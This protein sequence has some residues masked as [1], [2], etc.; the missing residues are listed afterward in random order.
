M[1]FRQLIFVGVVTFAVVELVLFP[2]SSRKLAEIAIISF[3]GMLQSFLKTGSDYADSME[4][5]AKTLRMGTLHLLEEAID[6]MV[7]HFA[8]LEAQK[9]QLKKTAATITTELPSAFLE[10]HF[11]FA[12]RL[13]TPSLSGLS[14]HLQA[15]VTQ[16]DFLTA[17]LK[18]IQELHDAQES[19][20]FQEID[21][22]QAYA[23]A[24][25]L[26][27]AQM[28]T[29]CQAL[30]Q[31][32]P[33]GRLRPQTKHSAFNASTAAATFRDFGDVRYQVISNW[34]HSF[35]QYQTENGHDSNNVVELRE[36]LLL[37]I[38]T[39]YI[40]ELAKHLQSAGKNLEEYART[41]PIS[42]V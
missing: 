9:E 17:A 29:S 6:A 32:F 39:S 34:A 40:L 42:H 22:T 11:G 5:E 14:S 36:I 41:F 35:Q 38:T 16:A 12:N 20:V 31:A 21:W 4:M 33:D 15:I 26:V 37:G 10:P 25:G 1:V 30:S 19:P 27:N 18:R 8:T 24:L 7:K 28:Q 13:D 3:F 2:R 23:T